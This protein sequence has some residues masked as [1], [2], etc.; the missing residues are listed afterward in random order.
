M[1]DRRKHA[2]GNHRGLASYFYDAQGDGLA[3]L[4][5]SSRVS[6]GKLAVQQPTPA[7]ASFLTSG[8]KKGV[9]TGPGPEPAGG[10][11]KRRQRSRSVTPAGGERARHSSTS[12]PP[13]VKKAKPAGAAHSDDTTMNQ[14]RHKHK[15][16][17]K[18]SAA[19]MKEHFKESDQIF[20]EHESWPLHGTYLQIN[21]HIQQCKTD[22]AEVRAEHAAPG[23]HKESVEAVHSTRIDIGNWHTGTMYDTLERE[24]AAQNVHLRLLL[25]HPRDEHDS[26]YVYVNVALAWLFAAKRQLMAIVEA[27]VEQM[28]DMTPRMEA[29][30]KACKEG[31]QAREQ[32][33]THKNFLGV[34]KHKNKYH[35]EDQRDLEYQHN[36]LLHHDP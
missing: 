15:E 10:P 29:F 14:T 33:L 16:G 28:A 1:P 5:Q 30:V 23:Q 11:P 12:R 32:Y 35:L 7:A 20:A 36:R 34:K 26:N 21:A 8:W 13:R 24:S 6:T 19:D 27:D 18:Q 25:R 31:R 22:I 2:D 17:M 3:P 9:W 4:P